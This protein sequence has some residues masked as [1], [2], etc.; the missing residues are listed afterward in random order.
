M[1]TILV[2]DLASLHGLGFF[3]IGCLNGGGQLHVSL[4]DELSK[5]ALH[6]VEKVYD[7]LK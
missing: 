6:N 7:S 3:F 2:C 1:I 4:S 5:Q